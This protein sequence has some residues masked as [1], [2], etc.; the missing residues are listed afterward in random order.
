[1]ERPFEAE[2]LI[3]ACREALTRVDVEESDARDIARSLV[4]ADARGLSSHGVSRMKVYTD[5]LRDGRIEPRA[6]VDVLRETPG[7]LLLDGNNGLGVPIAYRAMDRVIEKAQHVGIAFA[8]IR[9]SNHFGMAGLIAERAS[10]QGLI[11]YAASNGPSRMPAF[12]A[13]RPVFGTSP[14]A[15]AIPTGSG[16]PILI[17]MATCVVARGKIIMAA[18]AGEEIPEGWAVDADGRPTTDPHRALRGAVLPFAGPKGS[19]IATMIEVLTGVLGGDRWARDVEDL[20]GE[21]AG[22]SGTSH[23]VAALDIEA[24]IGREEFD[25][26]VA[27]LIAQIKSDPQDPGVP[28]HLPGEREQIAQE[29]ALRHG[30]TLPVDVVEELNTLLASLDIPPVRPTTAAPKTTERTP[31]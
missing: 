8:T 28:V 27:D 20:Y 31:A 24:L 5:R 29:A 30:V 10:N 14:F 22:P 2:A 19:A 21:D 11:G 4:L 25:A 15:C 12:G 7:T 6:T 23:C 16:S 26:N 18:R 17:D 3:Q 1:M 13:S 9:R